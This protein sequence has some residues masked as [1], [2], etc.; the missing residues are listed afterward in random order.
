MYILEDI[1]TWR[2]VLPNGMIEHR[3][4]NSQQFRSRRTNHGLT[5]ISPFCSGKPDV[6]RLVN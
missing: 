1:E 5:E 2:N 6:I 4:S 3:Q